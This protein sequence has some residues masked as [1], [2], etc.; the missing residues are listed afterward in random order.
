MRYKQILLR[1]NLRR[2]LRT[3]LVFLFL[4]IASEAHASFRDLCFVR[5]QNVYRWGVAKLLGVKPLPMDLYVSK[6]EKLKTDPSFYADPRK[7]YKSLRQFLMKKA[8]L[9]DEVASA[10][11]DSDV[12][13]LLYDANKADKKYENWDP[14]ALQIVSD[15]DTSR[16]MS[17][18]MDYVS[19]R[20]D[21]NAEKKAH[22][23]FDVIQS[24]PLSEQFRAS[25]ELVEVKKSKPSRRGYIFQGDVDE[26]YIDPDGVLYKNLPGQ[27]IK[28]NSE[29][30]IDM[31]SVRKREPKRRSINKLFES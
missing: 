17:R 22:I 7:V 5:L 2:R 28:I 10:R 25:F 6:L 30:E 19:L 31:N 26:L 14:I 3:H 23:V 16:M 12:K 1:S 24:I 8:N 27:Q 9:S 13:G 18:A 11:A 4:L 15:W 21:F 29:G 20:N